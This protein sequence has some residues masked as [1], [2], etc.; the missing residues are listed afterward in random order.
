MSEVST[1]VTIM[2]RV[3]NVKYLG[4]VQC[5]KATLEVYECGGCGYHVGLDASFLALQR[6][7]YNCPNCKAVFTEGDDN[8]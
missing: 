4:E 7:A 2:Y 3:H 1:N 8:G 6:R 5:G